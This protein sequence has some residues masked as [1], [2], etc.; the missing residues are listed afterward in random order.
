[1]CVT[2]M[3]VGKGNERQE[4]KESSS[5]GSR[6]LRLSCQRG[7][8]VVLEREAVRTAREL[9]SLPP[10]ST[11]LINREDGGTENVRTE[12]AELCAHE[13]E[14]VVCESEAARG[15]VGRNDMQQVPAAGSRVG[16]PCLVSLARHTSASLPIRRPGRRSCVTQR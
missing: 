9:L 5:C 13:W 3:K 10:A 11:H 4:T 8:E 15:T 1:V 6:P 14:R 7:K 2:Y 12:G 16:S